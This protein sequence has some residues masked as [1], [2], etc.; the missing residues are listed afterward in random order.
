MHHI[1]KFCPNC[2][3]SRYEWTL[4]LSLE[5]NPT[6]DSRTLCANRNFCN[7]DSRL[8]KIQISVLIRT[9]TQLVLCPVQLG[10]YLHMAASKL[11]LVVLILGVQH[12]ITADTICIRHLDHGSRVHWVYLLHNPYHHYP[13][14]ARETRSSAG[15]GRWLDSGTFD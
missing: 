10:P 3:Q 5:N 13:A 8:L 15:G 1:H 14:Q 9:K 6:T 2:I 4:H 12:E 11:V 7:T